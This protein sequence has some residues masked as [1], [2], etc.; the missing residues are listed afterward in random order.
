MSPTFTRHQLP[1]FAASLVLLAAC[2]KITAENYAKLEVGQDYQQATSVL[3]EPTRCDD[4]AGFKSCRWG[5]DKSNITVRFVGNKIAF[6]S[7]E[8]IK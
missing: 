3:G 1:V 7:A 4:M 6:L 5:D 8:N 2:S